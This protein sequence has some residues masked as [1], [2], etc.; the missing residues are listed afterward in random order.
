MSKTDFSHIF[1]VLPKELK[2]ELKNTYEKIKQNSL[3]G[4]DEPSELNGAKFAEVC[5]RILE[6]HTD[7][8]NEYTPFGTKIRNFSQE[9]K[10]FENKTSFPMS[11]R[12][13]IPGIISLLYEFRNH[14]GVGH[15]GG[16]VNP[17]NMD[18]SFVVSASDWVMAEFVRIFHKLS[19]EEAQGIV[20]RI[21]SIKIPVIWDI[22]G[23]KR[24]LETTLDSPAKTLLLLYSEYPSP[25]LDKTIFKWLE[26]SNFSV[27]V[28]IIIKGLH[29]EKFVEYD[30]E[31]KM[32]HLSPK[33][34]R[35]VEESIFP[36]LKLLG[37]A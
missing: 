36:K 12:L 2:D 1:S 6:W 10:K 11:I 3:E 4:K 28:N 30:A 21:V 26:H 24:V 7:P 23:T 9:C 35:H 15:V 22:G 32:I 13:H 31:T 34:C 16:D 29:K 20:E 27:F 18:S 8:Q 19:T 17:N 25:V 33:G 5:L 14:R 37:Y